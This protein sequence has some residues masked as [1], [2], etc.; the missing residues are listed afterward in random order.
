MVRIA[1]IC[2]NDTPPQVILRA[3]K[4]GNF[5]VADQND[6]PFAKDDSLFGYATTHSEEGQPDQNRSQIWR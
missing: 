2:E 4:Q 1:K 5:Y 3:G 6:I